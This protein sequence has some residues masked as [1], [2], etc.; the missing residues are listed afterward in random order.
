LVGIHNDLIGNTPDCETNGELLKALCSNVHIDESSNHLGQY[1]L[2]LRLKL[3]NDT[4]NR[5]IPCNGA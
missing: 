5:V 2:S 3:D 1:V 4:I